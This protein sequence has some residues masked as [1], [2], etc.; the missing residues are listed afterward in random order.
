MERPVEKYAEGILLLRT[1]KVAMKRQFLSLLRQTKGGALV[2][3]AVVFPVLLLFVIGVA[4]YARVYYAGITVANA[5]EAGAHYG[6]WY[7]GNVDSMAMAAQLDAGNVTLTAVT[8]GQFCRCPSTGVVAC[9]SGP[10]PDG[11]GVPQIYDSVWVR[12]DVAMLIPYPG[13]PS[14]ITVTRKAILREK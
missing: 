10:C 5:A 4:D 6:V 8:A 11:Y 7:S 14:T 13:L 12:K 3:L 1:R 2:E 9:D